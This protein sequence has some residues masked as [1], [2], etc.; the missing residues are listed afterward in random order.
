MR[1]FILS[2]MLMFALVFGVTNTASA[3]TINLLPLFDTNNNGVIYFG[4]G[5]DGIPPG[6]DHNNLS[7]INRSF[8]L[9]E[10]PIPGNFS[11]FVEASQINYTSSFAINGGQPNSVSNGSHTFTGNNTLLLTSNNTTSH[12]KITL[13]KS[14]HTQVVAWPK[15]F[16]HDIRTLQPSV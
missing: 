5:Y 6:L 13:V 8:D 12:L 15:S 7:Q 9:T 11:I 10:T 1:T 3:T 14:Q 16:P 2:M 4:D